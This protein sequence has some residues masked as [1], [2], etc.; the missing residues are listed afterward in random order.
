MHVRERLGTPD[1]RLRCG[2]RQPLRLHQGLTGCS[3]LLRNIA[4]LVECKKCNKTQ[5]EDRNR[6]QHYQNL[7][8]FI[9]RATAKKGKG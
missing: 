5:H 6:K 7:L 2:F 8:V 4:C 1:Q 9:Q 3:H